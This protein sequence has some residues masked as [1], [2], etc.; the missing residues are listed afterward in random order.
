MPLGFLPAFNHTI[1]NIG[2]IIY[3]LFFIGIVFFKSKI[4]PSDNR[5]NVDHNSDTGILQ[6]YSMFYTLGVCMILQGKCY[7]V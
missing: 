7:A 5:P 6:Q 1:S 4:L 3:G 2:Y